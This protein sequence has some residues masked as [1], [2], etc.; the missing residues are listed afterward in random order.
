L[1]SALVLAALLGLVHRL[2]VVVQS[3]PLHHVEQR[4]DGGRRAAF[5]VGILDAQQESPAGM[6]GHKPVED[7]R[8]DVADVH[9][10]RRRRR[11]T[12]AY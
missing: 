11:E 3:Q 7:G 12:N 5:Q 10:P 4:R 8:A 9:V 6:P 1:R 2:L